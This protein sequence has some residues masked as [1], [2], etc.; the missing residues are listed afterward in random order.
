MT[1]PT[2]FDRYDLPL[3][4]SSPLAA[5]HYI[6]GVDRLLGFDLDADVR[7][8][9]AI[10]A[11]PGFALAHAALA[12]HFQSQTRVPEARAAAARAQEL[13]G[14]VTPRERGHVAAVVALTE[15]GGPPALALLLEQLAEFPRE[16]LLLRQ[17]VFQ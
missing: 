8:Q 13:T 14:G 9:E 7:L 2:A 10:D 5:T 15:G 11:D 17:A 6:D 16:M 4:T 1:A 3:S 12:L